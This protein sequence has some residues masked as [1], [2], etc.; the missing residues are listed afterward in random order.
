MA[1][2]I[3][4]D[5]DALTTLL[6]YMLNIKEALDNGT[7]LIPSL[8]SQLD[9][10]ITGTAPSIASF[11][12]TFSGWITQLNAVTTDIDNAYS[13]LSAVLNDARNAVNAL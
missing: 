11:D 12:S 9:A 6:Q 4:V 3:K 8:T 2:T 1:G 7:S 10:A 5:I 13:T